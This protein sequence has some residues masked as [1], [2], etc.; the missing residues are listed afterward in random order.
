M[1]Y[2]PDQ[3]FDMNALMAYANSPAGKQLLQ[4]LQSC[5]SAELTKAME[6]ASKGNYHDAKKLVENFLQTTEGSQI[7]NHLGGRN[8]R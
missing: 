6:Y 7:S 5:K 4:M 1:A 8:G 2:K 3:N